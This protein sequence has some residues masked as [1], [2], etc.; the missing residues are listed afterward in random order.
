MSRKSEG[1]GAPIVPSTFASATENPNSNAAPVAPSGVQR[2]DH[3]RKGD[4][5]LSGGDVLAERPDRS[6]REGGAADPGDET[7]EDH[8]AVPREENP[9]P[10]VSAAVGCSPTARTRSPNG[11]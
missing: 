5:T 10:T 7:A 11:S 1:I 3:R 2:E 9:D 6:D 8:V 4:V